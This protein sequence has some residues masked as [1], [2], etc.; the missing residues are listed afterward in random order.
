MKFI[1]L[2]RQYEKLENEINENIQKLL[3]HEQFIMGP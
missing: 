2:R 1:D 3:E